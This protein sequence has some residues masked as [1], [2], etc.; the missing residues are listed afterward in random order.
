MDMEFVAQRPPAAASLLLTTLVASSAY[1]RSLS[2][3]PR[4]EGERQGNV[5]KPL[6]WGPVYFYISWP[7]M[8][9][10]PETTGSVLD[11]VES[12][13]SDSPGKENIGFALVFRGHRIVEISQYFPSRLARQT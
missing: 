9:F 11:L 12:S 7:D 5:H 1:I 6:P 2:L 4:S 13:T 8:L 3:P 10:P